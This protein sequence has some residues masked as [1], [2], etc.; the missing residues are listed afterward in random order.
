MY[1]EEINSRTRE[2]VAALVNAIQLGAAVIKTF[3]SSN[4]NVSGTINGGLIADKTIFEMG[5]SVIKS[6]LSGLI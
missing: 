5:A 6:E 1:D 2:S 3:S 4:Q